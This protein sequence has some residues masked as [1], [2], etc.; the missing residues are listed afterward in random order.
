MHIDQGG[1]RKAQR[2]F[3]IVLDLNFENDSLI[4]RPPFA[5]KHYPEMGPEWILASLKSYLKSPPP[6]C[7]FNH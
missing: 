7:S 6:S 1:N 2:D 4:E 3:T 5:R